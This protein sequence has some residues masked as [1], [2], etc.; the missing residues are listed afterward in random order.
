[1][2]SG[3]PVM[4]YLSVADELNLPKYVGKGSQWV[5]HGAHTKASL[6]A[7]VAQRAI[8]LGEYISGVA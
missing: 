4:G 2:H 8:C 3:Y 6:D 7:E 1:M 5:S